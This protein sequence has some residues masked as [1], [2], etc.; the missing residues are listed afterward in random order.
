MYIECAYLNDADMGRYVGT[1]NSKQK[2][3]ADK[4]L[5][6]RYDIFKAGVEKAVELAGSA[7]VQA[8]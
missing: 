1:K 8:N 2:F 6:G 7:N 3:Y 5:E 4:W